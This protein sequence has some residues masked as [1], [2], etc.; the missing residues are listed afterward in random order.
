MGVNFGMGQD[1]TRFYGVTGVRHCLNC[2][3]WEGG[4]PLIA[5]EVSEIGEI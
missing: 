2:Y 5:K 3:I 1:V 4:A